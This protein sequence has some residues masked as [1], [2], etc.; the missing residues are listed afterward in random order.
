MTAEGITNI[1]ALPAKHWFVRTSPNAAR[2]EERARHLQAWLIALFEQA[3]F[4][5]SVPA[6]SGCE[7]L[8]DRSAALRLFLD[9]ARG[10][11][12][13]K[14]AA[15]IAVQQHHEQRNRQPRD[16]STHRQPFSLP[17]PSTAI[18]RNDGNFETRTTSTEEGKPHSQQTPSLAWKSNSGTPGIATPSAPSSSSAATS[19][20]FGPASAPQASSDFSFAMAPRLDAVS[21]DAFVAD[22]VDAYGSLP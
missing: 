5:P 12:T 18:V 3:N 6:V 22:P 7:T 2:R 20:S 16:K 19:S 10:T 1:P 13:A 4:A 21:E 17:A 14:E 11:Q 15:R 8:L 9:H